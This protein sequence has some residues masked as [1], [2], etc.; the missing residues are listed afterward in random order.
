VTFFTESF[1]DDAA[2]MRYD[3]RMNNNEL[4]RIARELRT[5]NRRNKLQIQRKRARSA[6]TKAS[7]ESFQHPHRFPTRYKYG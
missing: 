5:T 1:L 6:Y 4:R 7:L 3:A 2:M